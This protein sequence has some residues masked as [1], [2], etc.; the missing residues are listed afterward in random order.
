MNAQLRPR[1]LLYSLKSTEETFLS[2]LLLSVILWKDV[3]L[4]EHSAW[5]QFC[6]NSV[7]GNVNLIDKKQ[8]IVAHLKEGDFYE[9]QQM[10]S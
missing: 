3:V 6:L 2:P 5:T 7:E 1:D 9:I 4:L 8:C 10:M